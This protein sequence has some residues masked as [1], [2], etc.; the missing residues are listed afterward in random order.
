M[1]YSSSTGCA[2]PTMV[3]PHPVRRTSKQPVTSGQKSDFGMQMRARQETFP[4][5]WLRKQAKNDSIR[6]APL[7]A[8][9]TVLHGSHGIAFSL[10]R[11]AAPARGGEA[12][13]EVRRRVVESSPVVDGVSVSKMSE[14]CLG[15]LVRGFYSPPAGVIM[16]LVPL[17]RGISWSCFIGDGLAR[18]GVGKGVE[19]DWD[20]VACYKCVLQTSCRRHP[21]KQR[22]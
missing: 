21:G 8:L 17:R 1:Q 4:S 19:D 12:R 9:V 10:T 11:M 3:L 20:V 16:V 13:I 7:T 18:D 22:N 14:P 6:T 2:F 15:V 5:L